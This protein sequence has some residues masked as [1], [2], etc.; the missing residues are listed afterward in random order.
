MILITCIPVPGYAQYIDMEITIESEL[1]TSVEQN[2]DFGKYASN[3]GK[4]SIAFGDQNMGIVG[5]RAL[6]NQNLFIEFIPPTVLKSAN[7]DNT[8]TIPVSLSIDYDNSGQNNINNARPLK[9]NREW[10]AI[11][12]DQNSN[13]NSNWKS[14]HLYIFGSLN[15]EN[16][17]E[18]IYEGYALLIVDY[19]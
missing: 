4:V 7:S 17:P 5:I 6:K 1:S 16:I 18:D 14:I 19:E 8:Y 2:L 15:I 3:A 11:L 10:V 12:P 13:R 9:N